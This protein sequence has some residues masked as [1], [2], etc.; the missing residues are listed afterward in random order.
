MQD[1]S[2]V[3]SKDYTLHQMLL[4]KQVGQSQTDAKGLHPFGLDKKGAPICPNLWC[5]HLGHFF[6]SS[7]FI[8]WLRIQNICS[9]RNVLTLS[10][11]CLFT[12]CAFEMGLDSWWLCNFIN[13]SNWKEWFWGFHFIWGYVFMVCTEGNQEDKQNWTF[14][15][16]NALLIC[17]FRQH[18]AK[19]SCCCL[20][21]HRVPPSS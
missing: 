7:H 1:S 2:S 18:N 4:I 13:W 3:R 20:K 16:F 14:G 19:E 8:Q 11:S 9:K 12:N 15:D 5:R 17:H 21:Y 6:H 10:S